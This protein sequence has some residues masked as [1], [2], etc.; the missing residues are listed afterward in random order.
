MKN[1]QKKKK[2]NNDPENLPLRSDEQT[3]KAKF[4]GHFC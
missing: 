2:Q 4:I 3:N 1:N